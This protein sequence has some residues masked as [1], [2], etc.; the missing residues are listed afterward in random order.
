MAISLIR[1]RVKVQILRDT[2][3]V[4]RVSFGVPLFIGTTDEGVRAAS[5]ANLEEVGAVYAE[6]TPEYK[7]ALA[8]F[9]QQP[10][11]RQL[12]IGFKDDT[13]SYTEALTEIR[14]VNDEWFCVA[15]ESRNPADA[16]TMAPAVS[17]LPGLRQFWFVSSDVNT[18]NPADETNIAY[19]L[20]E[21]N[22][23][24]ARVVF[25]RQGATIFPDM[26][27]LGRVLP[28]PE[29][30]TSGPGTAAWHDQPIVGITGESFTSTE[31]SALESFNAEFFINVA[32]ATRAMGGKMAG[33]EWGDVMHFV[34]WL[35]T[36]LAEDVYELMARAA[37]RR[38]KIPY[39]DAGIA[40]VEST[41]RNRLDIGVSIG[42]I[43]DDFTVTVPRREDTQFG[44]RANRVLKDVNFE[45]NLAGAIKFVE[46]SGVVTA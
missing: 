14:V 42:G 1:D 40:R 41:V 39:S 26:A 33:G 28:I 23:D 32:G 46:I 45:A 11:P 22:F 3:A 20:R 12:I 44:D 38:E 9:S 7:A 21:L 10:Q 37:N 6:S 36:R 5:Y 16:L 29:S 13:E 35:E 4:A 27:M 17:A 8:F 18:L 19:Q 31:R 30:R 15:I 24:Q 25:H 34:A 43:L 2:S